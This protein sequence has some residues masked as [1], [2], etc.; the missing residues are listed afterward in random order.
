MKRLAFFGFLLAIFVV[1]VLI[2]IGTIKAEDKN[3]LEGIPS[4]QEREG[5]PVKAVPVNKGLFEVW[6]DI[7]GQ[8]KGSKQ[9]HIRTPDPAKVK[10][11]KYKI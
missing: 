6:R 1:A 5:Y 9:A 8:V 10:E 3:K 11:I 4:T 7:Q 2:R